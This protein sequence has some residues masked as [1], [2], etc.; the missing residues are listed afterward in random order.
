[1][2][3]SDFASAELIDAWDRR[4]E[5]VAA[6]N[7]H[8][9][10]FS[11]SN[12]TNLISIYGFPLETSVGNDFRIEVYDGSEV[13]YSAADT[14]HLLKDVPT[15]TYYIRVVE[16][17]SPQDLDYFLETYIVENGVYPPNLHTD[18]IEF[19]TAD[20]NAQGE[21]YVT[22]KSVEF[23]SEPA[24]SPGYDPFLNKEYVADSAAATKNFTAYKNR[25][26]I[27]IN[28]INNNKIFGNQ[29]IPQ[30]S[31]SGTVKR[32]GVAVQNGLIRLYDRA[33]GELIEQTY[34]DAT[35]NYSFAAR[36]DPDFKYYIVAFDDVD[37]PILQ[38]V[39]HDFLDPILETL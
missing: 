34:S 33:S 29:A 38:A 15:G 31:I 28:G 2:P 13:I 5:F 4:M 30:Y 17:G 35:G 9:Y 6:S 24:L 3:G 10:R 21:N 23:Y 39:I 1:M 20:G 37:N 8:Y 27:I 14:S 26:P 12:S 22:M 32:E 11:I 25:N 36:I 19:E 16:V 18:I 7:S